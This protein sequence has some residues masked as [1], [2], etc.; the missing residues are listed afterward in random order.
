MGHRDGL[1]VRRRDGHRRPHCAGQ[2]HRR[3][4]IRGGRVNDQELMQAIH[5]KYGEEITQAVQGT[6]FPAALLAALTANESG[7]DDAACRFEAKTYSEL[8]LVA[9]GRKAASNGIGG[10]DLQKWLQSLSGHAAI[11]ALLNLA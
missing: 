5:A 2:G 10:E 9:I 7:L 8:S 11:A 4:R 6:P 3:L 1:H